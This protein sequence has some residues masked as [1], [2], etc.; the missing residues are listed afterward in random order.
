MGFAGANDDC[1]LAAHS[2]V[3][4]AVVGAAVGVVGVGVEQA[5]N[6]S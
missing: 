2:V 4:V 3:A 1:G 5:E 6:K